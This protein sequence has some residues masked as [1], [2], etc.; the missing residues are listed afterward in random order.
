[1][2]KST[3]KKKSTKNK[4][5]TEEDSDSDSDDETKSRVTRK[6][7]KTVKLESDPSQIFQVEMERLQQQISFLKS[8]SNEELFEDILNYIECHDQVAYR[9]KIKGFRLAFNIREK[10]HRIPDSTMKRGLKLRSKQSAEDIKRRVQEM[11]QNRIQK[12]EQKKAQ[13]E[14]KYQKNRNLLKKMHEKMRTEKYAEMGYEPNAS[15]LK[16]SKILNF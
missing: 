13:H 15:Y 1:M 5:D 8:K 4:N 12:E 16:N 3:K 2:S 10:N 7:E 6:T 14:Q 9:K 11:K